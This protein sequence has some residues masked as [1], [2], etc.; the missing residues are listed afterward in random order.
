[1]TDGPYTA[2]ATG[3]NW[4]VAAPNMIRQA[5]SQLAADPNYAGFAAV[6]LQLAAVLANAGKDGPRSSL[7]N[8]APAPSGSWDFADAT[9]VYSRLAAKYLQRDIPIYDTP[10][11][12]GDVHA[13]H[14]K[15]ADGTFVPNPAFVQP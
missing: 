9:Y 4:P 15:Y 14:I 7:A 3:V 2:A 6:D 13:G 8:A 11:R 10:Y 12:S 1:M 5:A